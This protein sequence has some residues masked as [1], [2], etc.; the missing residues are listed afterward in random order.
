ME[1]LADKLLARLDGVKGTGKDRWIAKCPSHEDRT[2]SLA[3]REVEDRLLLHC[4]AGCSV[5]EIVLA[6]GLALNDLFPPRPDDPSGRKRERN[7][8]YAIDGLRCIARESLVVKLAADALANGEP[9]SADDRKRMT[10]AATRIHLALCAC[11]LTTERIEDTDRSMVRLGA[12]IKQGSR[13]RLMEYS[14][15]GGAHELRKQG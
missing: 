13:E 9:F 4:F 2:P 6:A 15:T 7:P 11:G 12:P 3:V 14:T 5:G 1:S 10:C 8:F